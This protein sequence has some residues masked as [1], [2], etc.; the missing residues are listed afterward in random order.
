M[1]QQPQSIENIYLIQ[2]LAAFDCNQVCNWA[3]LAKSN[4][5]HT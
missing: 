3:S 2:A 4:G 1:S 5:L